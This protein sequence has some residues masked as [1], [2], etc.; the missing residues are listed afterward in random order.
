M[1]AALSIAGLPTD[2][3]CSRDFCPRAARATPARW[4]DW[5]RKPRT[6]VFFEAPHRIADTLA[7]LAQLFG[8]QRRAVVAR[9]LTKLHEAVYR[10]TLEELCAACAAGSRTCRAAKSH[11]WSRARR[12]GRPPARTGV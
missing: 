9:E 3:F 10:G 4:R 2:R 11:W 6:L 8:G 7:D 1:T 12:A 5:H